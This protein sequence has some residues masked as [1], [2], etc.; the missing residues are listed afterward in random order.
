M[1]V[2][3]NIKNFSGNLDKIT[4]VGQSAGGAHLASAIFRRTLEDADIHL[5]GSILLSAP[6]WYDLRQERR[7]KN[8][9]LY[10]ETESEEE[11]LSKAGASSFRDSTS[12]NLSAENILL[13]LGQFDSNEIVDGNLMFVEEYRKKFSKLP[14]LEIIP[15]HNHISYYLSLGLEGNL[16]GRRILEFISQ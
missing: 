14:L 12:Q 13:M 3:D 16:L 10:H 1:Y 4:A 11:V 6:L 9:F 8:M 15:G 2:R 7:R 5:R